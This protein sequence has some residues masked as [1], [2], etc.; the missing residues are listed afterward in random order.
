MS[1][2]LTAICRGAGWR[3]LSAIVPTLLGQN[4][5]RIVYKNKL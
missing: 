1:V 3:V 4:V 2:S 5:T